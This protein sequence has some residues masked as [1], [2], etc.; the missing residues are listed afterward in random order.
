MN[1]KNI[2][3]NHHHQPSLSFFSESFF[4]VTDLLVLFNNSSLSELI[5]MSENFKFMSWRS[6]F[7]LENAEIL[8]DS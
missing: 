8:F 5:Y 6:C 4:I 3:Q 7:V 2:T 1:T